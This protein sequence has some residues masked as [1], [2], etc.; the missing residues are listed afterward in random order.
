[1][2][3]SARENTAPNSITADSW[4]PA[5][6][7]DRKARRTYWPSRPGTSDS[8]CDEPSSARSAPTTIARTRY[9]TRFGATATIA[10]PRAIAFSRWRTSRHRNREHVNQGQIAVAERLRNE[11]AIP[12]RIVGGALDVHARV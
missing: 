4:Q 8:I 12:D 9:D 6:T 10:A 7:R 5:S 2:R 1:M 11:Q 3:A